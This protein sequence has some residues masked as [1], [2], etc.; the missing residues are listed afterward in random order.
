MKLIAAGVATCAIALGVVLPASSAAADACPTQMLFEVGG[1]GDP[2][3]NVFDAGN[4]ELPPG[5][6]ATKVVYP[7]EI[8]PLAP[9]TL[10]DSNAEGRA[11]MDRLVREFHAS[12]PGSR[13]T[14]TGFSQGALVAGDT[15]GN[16]SKDDRIP[17]GLIN[18]VLY[19]DA[20]RVGVNGG[21]GGIMTN[22]P[23]FLPGITMGG[24]RT[25][26]D[27]PVVSLCNQN[28]GIC[29]SEN[30][31]TNLLGFANGIQGY[32][33]GAHSAYDFRPVTHNGS[34]NTVFPQPPLI[35]YGPP[36]PLPIP[37]LWELFNGK[38]A[39]AGMMNIYRSAVSAVL[40]QATKDRLDEFPGL[41]S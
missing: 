32:F 41:A 20:R 6:E 25:F 33:S 4:A 35:P 29:H 31:L 12:C 40:P 17:H 18:G 37:T 22:L 27:I 24:P 23:T 38:P 16:L 26:G 13:I 9:K 10:D 19:S 30:L 28:D 36:L 15:L 1:M 34:A 14:I 39:A 5:V 8:F 3:G 11:T 2:Q 21:P 7:A